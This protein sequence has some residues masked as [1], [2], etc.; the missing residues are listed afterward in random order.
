MHAAD[1]RCSGSPANRTHPVSPA[2]ELK[3][4]ELFYASDEAMT[5]Q[6]APASAHVTRL[7]FACNWIGGSHPV[8]IF[9]NTKRFTRVA[10]G[11]ALVAGVAGPLTIAESVEASAAPATPTCSTNQITVAVEADSGAYSAAGNH[12]VPFAIINVGHA[13]CSLEGY[14]KLQFYP[15]YYKGKSVKVTD[16]GGGQILATV[17]PRRIVI[18]PGA[19]AS[20]GINYGDAYNQ[21]DPNGAPCMTQ[22]VTASLPVQPHPY[23][24][25]F[26]VPLILNF[27]FTDFHFGVTSIQHGPI[28]RTN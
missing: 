24:V 22:S 1:R 12:A 27:C 10:I 15:S 25:P 7:S 19:T 8:R 28:P 9:Q 17:P 23:S 4:D 11:M 3:R 18:E 2:C 21:G 13:A 20:F 26:I 6:R 14:P 16:N 5:I